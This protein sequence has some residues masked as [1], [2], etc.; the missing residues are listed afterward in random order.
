MSYELDFQWDPDKMM[1]KQIISENGETILERDIDPME[2]A[3]LGHPVM[4]DVIDWAESEHPTL[5]GGASDWTYS[6]VIAA[7]KKLKR[8]ERAVEAYKYYKDPE[9]EEED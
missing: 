2:V 1:I 3:K 7:Y 5:F 6:D 4:H 8:M 9:D